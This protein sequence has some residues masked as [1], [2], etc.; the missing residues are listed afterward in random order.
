MRWLVVSQ[1]VVC[2]G[3]SVWGGVVDHRLVRVWLHGSSGVVV[4]AVVVVVVVVAV[5]AVVVVVVV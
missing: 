2:G 3:K 1:G 5:V 4:V